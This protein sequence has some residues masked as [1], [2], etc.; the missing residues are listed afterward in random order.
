MRDVAHVCVG[1]QLARSFEREAVFAGGLFAC[2]LWIDA[3]GDQPPTATAARSDT[4]QMPHDNIVW[5][6]DPAWQS[7]G[8]F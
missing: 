8:G 3:N 4:N 2:A 1:T 7:E 5:A 6:G